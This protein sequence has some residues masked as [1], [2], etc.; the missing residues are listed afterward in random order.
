VTAIPLRVD[1]SLPA[2]AD[3]QIGDWFVVHPDE[4]RVGWIEL[5]ESLIDGRRTSWG[6]AGVC[7]N[8]VHEPSATPGVP[9]KRTVYIVE[10][11]PGGAV[12]REWHWEGN[13]H[14]WS[15]GTGLSNT[16]MGA[17]AQSLKGVGYS[18]ADYLAIEAHAA[19]MDIPGLREF[20]ESTHHIMCSQLVDVS[21]QRALKPVKLFD[22]GRWNGFVK[23]SNLGYLLE[24]AHGLQ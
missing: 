18:F 4:Y 6:H 17:S 13:P 3:V 10:A 11:E 9:A 8:I 5:G 14:L 2:T 12:E 23:P 24:K 22:D 19:R 20:I 7:S 21:A 1:P 15:T 16:T